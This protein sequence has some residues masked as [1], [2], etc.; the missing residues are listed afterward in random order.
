TDNLIYTSDLNSGGTI[1]G[2]NIIGSAPDGAHDSPTDGY[3]EGTTHIYAGQTAG[4]ISLSQTNFLD[5]FPATP[6]NPTLCDGLGNC[7][8]VIRENGQTVSGGQQLPGYAAGYV[9]KD[10]PYSIAT[11]S[12]QGDTNECADFYVEWHAIDGPISESGLGDLIGVD[13]EL[14]YDPDGDQTLG[15]GTDFDRIWSLEEVTVTN[16]ELNCGFNY[17]IFGDVSD[18]SSL[19]G[20]TG[21]VVQGHEGH[22]WDETNCAAYGNLKTYNCAMFE[23]TQDDAYLGDDSDHDYNGTNGRL[24]LKFD[25]MCTHDIMVRHVMLE[26]IEVGAGAES[27]LSDYG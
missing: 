7:F 23:S 24:I 13:E 9:I 6:T 18:E 14:D 15:D 21:Q 20:C 27:C 16:M 3:V 11:N 17:P 22:M 19:N 8:D 12:G 26:F 10:P 25:P 5:Q 1:P 4:S 2:T